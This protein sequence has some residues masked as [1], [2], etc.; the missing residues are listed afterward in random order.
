MRSNV[1]NRAKF[2]AAEIILGLE[3]LHGLGILHRDL[4]LENVL[5]DKDGHVYLSDFYEATKLGEG[6]MTTSLVGTPEFMGIKK[7]L[8]G[9]KKDFLNSTRSDK[10]RRIWENN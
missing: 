5:M 3:Y 6:K 10:S 7:F 4:K 2:Y 1:T 9:E 8:G